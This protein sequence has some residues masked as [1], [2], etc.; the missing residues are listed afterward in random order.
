M[1]RVL[2]LKGRNV[3]TKFTFSSPFITDQLLQFQTT[4]KHTILLKSQ[5]YSTTG[6]TSGS[7][8]LYKVDA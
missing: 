6:L 1:K 8:Q 4:N 5:N 2:L 7:T 3:F